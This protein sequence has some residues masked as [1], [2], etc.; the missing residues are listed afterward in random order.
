M[1]A[2]Q[3]TELGQPPKLVELDSPVVIGDAPESEM[4]DLKLVASGVHS[5]VRGRAAGK[6]YSAKGLPHI[7]GVDGVFKTPEGKLVFAAALSLQGGTMAEHVKLPRKSLAP[8]P[9]ATD[10]IQTAGLV[11]PIMASWMALKTRVSDLP[12]DFTCVIVGVTAVS[13]MCAINVAREFGAG[14]VI[15]VARNPSK[16]EG[17]G[18][19]D[20]IK[21]E[22]DVEKTDFSKLPPVDVI[23]DFLFGPIIPHLFRSLTRPP[24]VVQYVQ[25]GSVASLTAE[26]P[27][28]QLRSKNIVMSGAGPG[29]WSLQQFAEETPKMVNIVHKIKPYKFQL[30]PLAEVE[31]TWNKGGDRLI[32]VP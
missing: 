6:H 13:G 1:K 24:R 11:N 22:D 8:L 14:K 4:V 15:G 12:K 27:A 26:L 23:L 17:L 9:E 7:P 25:V 30:V 3:V 10:P 5:L 2:V 32:V 19:D 20:A 18:L 31:E 29:A 16:M 28:D 21:M